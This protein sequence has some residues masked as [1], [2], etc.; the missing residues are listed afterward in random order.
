M[1]IQVYN[2]KTPNQT[3]SLKSNSSRSRKSGKVWVI[4]ILVLL[5]LATTG[6]AVFFYYKL[7]EIQ[8]N[9]QQ[10]TIDETKAIVEKVGKLLT[11][12]PKEQPTLATVLD[13]DKLKDQA[14][15]NDARNG[16]KILI[17]TEAKKAIIYRESTD[18]IINVGPILL[19]SEAQDPVKK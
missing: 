14:F 18:K 6:S 16:D 5:S 12:P 15:F 19:N 4:G 13:K 10:V 9:P 8:D 7:R 3:N 17:Y 11:L 2:S 1:D